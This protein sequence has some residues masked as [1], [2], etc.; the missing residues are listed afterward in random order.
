MVNILDD[1]I[2][3]D[4]SGNPIPVYIEGDAPETLPDE[5]FTVSEDY[6]SDLISADNKAYAILYEFTLKYY[7]INAQTLSSRMIQALTLLK[8]KKYITTGVGY[9]N[10]TYE[11]K[12]FSKQADVEKIDYI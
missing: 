5:Y 2:L 11:K 6:T 7:T 4:D 9:G 1:L 10:G 3:N 8:S 12:W